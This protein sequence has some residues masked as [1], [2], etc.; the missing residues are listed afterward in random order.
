MIGFSFRRVLLHS[1]GEPYW[2]TRALPLLVL[3]CGILIRELPFLRKAD[4]R[5][6]LLG[7]ISNNCCLGCYFGFIRGYCTSFP[8]CSALSLSLWFSALPRVPLG[9]SARPGGLFPLSSGL[10]K[11]PSEGCSPGGLEPA[12]LQR[13]GDLSYTVLTLLRRPSSRLIAAVPWNFPNT[14]IF[15]M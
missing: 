6:F 11:G 1:R 10:G 3:Y 5:C 14:Q 2:V 4:K 13:G 9:L 15:V 12:F 8:Y 7:D